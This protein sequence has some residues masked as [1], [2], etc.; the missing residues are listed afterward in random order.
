M[1]DRGKLYHILELLLAVFVVIGIIS[2]SLDLVSKFLEKKQDPIVVVK[3]DAKETTNVINV[4]IGGSVSLETKTLS[5]NY[6]E[7]LT[8]VL[9]SY[10]VST[11]LQRSMVDTQLSSSFLKQ[12]KDS[13]WKKV[14][15]ANRNSAKFQKTG[16]EK[17]L[18]A[19]QQ[20]GI[21]T[22][23][24]YLST[25]EKN[26]IFIETIN[27]I[28]VAYVSLTDRLNDVLPEN[29]LYLV[30]KYDDYSNYD[31]VA[32]AADLAD[33]VIV[34][35]DWDGGIE[36][37]PTQRQE[38]I[39]QNLAWAGASVIVGNVPNK[40]QPVE[41]IDDTLV[42]YSLSDMIGNHQSESILGAVTIS[43]TTYMDKVK[44]ELTNSRVDIL[45]YDQGKLALLSK[46]Q[47]NETIKNKYQQIINDIMHIRDDSIGI[48]GIE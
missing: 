18:N 44:V 43:K 24:N 38:E 19:F 8:P 5:T 20:E 39:A 48:G 9:S 45:G 23:G 27:Q 28:R 7:N 25:D 22:F 41:W 21:E 17:Q 46:Y 12:V 47:D 2:L 1:K 34:Y 29:E 15:L 3:N 10:D 13:G 4:L 37:T 33:V 42:F 36:N 14:A 11:Y 16:I 32:K 31:L 6:F 40:I 35:I 26:R 30:E